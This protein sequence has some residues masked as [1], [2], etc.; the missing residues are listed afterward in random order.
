MRFKDKM[1]FVTGGSKGLGKA[2]V[3]KFLEEGAKVGTNG[4]DANSLQILENECKKDGDL[5]VYQ[6]DISDYDR[7]E[8]IA[9]DFVAKYGKIDVLINNAGIVNPLVPSEQIKKEDFD[10]VIDVNL[11]GTFYT[12]LVFGKKMIEKRHGRIINISSQAGFFG[13]KGFLPY[14]VSKG[15]IMLMT[16]ILA[17]EWA[18]YGVTLCSVAP[19]FIKGGMNENLVKKDV[20]VEFLSRRTPYGRMGEVDEF[21]SLILFLASNESHYIN[22]ETITLDGGMTGYVTEALIDFIASLKKER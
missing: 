11:K 18:K 12:T 5:T 6:G 3:L 10:K 21:V 1:V 13:E 17:Y 14:A 20:F 8:E 15:A 7:M 19:G 4:R 16:R 2:L 9:N 22:G